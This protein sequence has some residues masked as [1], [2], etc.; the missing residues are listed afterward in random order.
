MTNVELQAYN[1]ITQLP[2]LLSKDEPS[3]KVRLHHQFVGQAIQGIMSNDNLLQVLCN[4]EKNQSIAEIITK[5]AKQV[6]DLMIEK[7][8]YK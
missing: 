5:N 7:L 2:K 3:Y 6:A 4:G 8:D 1:A